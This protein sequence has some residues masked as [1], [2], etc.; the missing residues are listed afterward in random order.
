[1]TE[2]DFAR[3]R[4]R[5]ADAGAPNGY[6]KWGDPLPAEWAIARPNGAATYKKA[7]EEKYGAEEG[8][9]RYKCAVEKQIKKAEDKWA[10]RET[11]R[12][13]L[14]SAYTDVVAAFADEKTGARKK[15]LAGQIIKAAENADTAAALFVAKAA[16]EFEPKMTDAEA[17]EHGVS[18]RKVIYKVVKGDTTTPFTD[19]LIA[20][21]AEPP[22]LPPPEIDGTITISIDGEA[23]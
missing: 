13:L 19:D 12:E 3:N 14:M 20:R 4:S 23:E 6:N 10:T 18:V 2:E 7:F 22:A 1:M 21:R 9:E 5:P 8:A 16:G 11:A 17:E 15:I